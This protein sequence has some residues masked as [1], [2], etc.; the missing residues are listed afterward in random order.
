MRFVPIESEEQQSLLVIHRAR[1]LLVRQRMSLSV[2]FSL[3][4]GIENSLVGALV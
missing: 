3:I 1:D 2:E 4:V